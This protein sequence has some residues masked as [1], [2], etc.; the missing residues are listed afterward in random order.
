MNPAEDSTVYI[1]KPDMLFGSSGL[2]GNQFHTAWFLLS[3]SHLMELSYGDWAR[4]YCVLCLHDSR[5]H[6]RPLR[7]QTSGQT[8]VV[9]PPDGGGGAS[10]RRKG[11]QRL[12]N[13]WESWPLARL[14][15]ALSPMS[16]LDPVPLSLRMGLQQ[17]K[18]PRS[19]ASQV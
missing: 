8:V 18:Q 6:L 15:C 11:Q 2:F 13:H 12:G 14:P 19:D 16:P 4:V 5:V 9:K 17:Q 3:P 10:A 1:A 7:G